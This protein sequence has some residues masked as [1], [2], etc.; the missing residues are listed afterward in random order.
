M[1][2]PLLRPLFAP[3]GRLFDLPPGRRCQQPS[4]EMSDMRAAA[5]AA[6]GLS[7]AA[8]VDDHGCFAEGEVADGGLAAARAAAEDGLRAMDELGS[9][10]P[11]KPV[12]ASVVPS[13]LVE[14]LNAS[15][16]RAHCAEETTRGASSQRETDDGIHS[17][18][19]PVSL[20]Y[21]E[22]ARIKFRVSREGTRLS[23]EITSHF[24]NNPRGTGPREP[25]APPTRR[26]LRRRRVRG[27]G[28]T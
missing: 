7:G 27:P 13:Q 3:G 2:C 9:L 19:P 24:P 6:L 11:P 16:F 17:L 1:R 25:P 8:A 5:A 10:P 23:F 15:G 12:P 14:A 4:R 20:R 26:A 22:G 28:A 18:K 21:S